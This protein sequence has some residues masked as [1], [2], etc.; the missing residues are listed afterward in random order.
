MTFPTYVGSSVAKATVLLIATF[1]I[2]SCSAGPDVPESPDAHP[3]NPTPAKAVEVPAEVAPEV[4]EPKE[5]PID[6]LQKTH[7]PAFH[8]S[9]L[10]HFGEAVS[11]AG[12]RIDMGTV[13][14]RKYINGGWRSGW[15][16]VPRKDDDETYFEANRKPARVFASLKK[17]ASEVSLRMKAAKKSNK[18]VIY[19]NDET[20]GDV[21]LTS[22]W[23]DFTFAVPKKA[24]K[25]GEQNL[26]IRFR[27]D[28]RLDKRA[29]AGHVA[30]VVFRHGDGDFPK[31]PYA[32]QVTLGDKTLIALVAESEVNQ[33]F[34]VQVPKEQPRLALRLG[35]HSEKATVKVLANV[36]GR[37]ALTLYDGLVPKDAWKEEVL[38]LKEV[39][40]QVAELQIV[41]G[42]KVSEAA[43]VA[44]DAA[45]YEPKIERQAKP[46]GKPA[47]NV[48]VYLIDTLRYD[49]IGVYNDKSS[50][51][52]PNFDDF[53]LDATIFDYA[54]DTENWTKPSTASILTGLLPETHRAKDGSAKVPQSA[55]FVSEHLQSQ[56]FRTGSF[57]ANGYVSDAFGFKQGWHSYTNYIREEKVTDAGRLVDDAL[58][59]IDKNNDERWFAYVHTIDPHVPYSAPKKWKFKRWNDAGEGKYRGPIKPQATGNQLADIKTGKLKLTDRD[60]R[61]LEHLYDSE[62]EYNDTEFGRLIKGLKERGVYDDTVILIMVDHG[63][64]FF[65]HGSVG[66]GHSLYE[67]LVHTPFIVRYPGVMPSGARVQDVVSMTDVVPGMLD[68]LGVPP[69][70]D[71][72]GTSFVDRVRTGDTPRPHVAVTEF[73]YRH[74]SLHSGRYHWLTPGYG[75]ELFDVWS[76]RLE[77]KS[78]MKSHPIALAY[79]RGHFGLYEG[80]PD[81]S[82]WWAGDPG[83]ERRLLES[84]KA[85]V[86]P[87]LQ[88]QLEAM[89]YIDGATGEHS[90]EDDK[91]LMEK[92]D[93]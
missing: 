7:E 92:E 37:D 68:V 86:D 2:A 44:F 48:L 47:K 38:D 85:A 65:D 15:S 13:G 16:P 17:G 79:I 20:L 88:K 14:A 36:D 32:D 5:S 49:K 4:P 74:K 8:M 62:V 69:M 73:L 91:K 76:D 54:Y 10:S 27:Y 70:K 87:E 26:L 21:K 1:F 77:K 40:G 42:G 30:Q 39:A 28:T 89:G 3:I 90:A 29:Q 82:K 63:E 72:E 58:K 81:K 45:L 57:I 18:A 60:K 33:S 11:P 56:G 80:A 55:V 59:F 6:V 22:E 25:A 31:V 71:V 93:K 19:L 61:Y 35:G 67:E 23:Q 12:V 64:E 66:H 83:E 84:D 78:L 51:P 34:R 53:A 9:V 46:Q 50:V 43:S 41:V 24:R 52:T 75:G